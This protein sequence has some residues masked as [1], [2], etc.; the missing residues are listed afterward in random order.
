ME[1][2]STLVS[3]ILK[4]VLPRF[5]RYLGKLS[6]GEKQI[7]PNI[8]A[9]ISFVS[10]WCKSIQFYGMAQYKDTERDTIDLKID[11]LPRKFR[12]PKKASPR[13]GEADLLTDN[14]NYI[15]L[16]DPGSGK[17]T[18]LKRLAVRMLFE[19]PLKGDVWQFPIVIRIKDLENEISFIEYLAN[20]LGIPFRHKVETV[21][22][23]IPWIEKK[24][25]KSFALERNQ[26]MEKDAEGR[27]KCIVETVAK[28]YV[29]D[30]YLIN[31]LGEILSESRALLLL[32]GLDEVSEKRKA[33]L[34]K[35][36]KSLSD[37]AN[38]SKIIVSCRSGDYNRQIEGFNV[39]EIFPLDRS[40][41]YDIAKKWLKDPKEFLQ[42][43]ESCPYSDLSDRPLFLTQL[44]VIYD[45]QGYLPDQP[46]AV[47]RKMV[48]LMLE[49]WDLQ[50]GIKRRSAYSS[51]TPERKLEF[52]AA[53]SY[54]LTYKSRLKV[55]RE[56]DLVR[57]YDEICNSFRLPQDEAIYVAQEI[58]THTGLMVQSGG[59]NFEF[60]H[61]SLQEYLCAYY[62]VR[63]SFSSHIEEYLREYPAPVAIA[64]AISSD[65]SSW[66]AKLILDKQHFPYF[67]PESVVSFLSR[68]IQEKPFFTYSIALG[69]ALLNICFEFPEKTQEPIMLLLQDPYVE[70]SFKEALG[71]YAPLKSRSEKNRIYLGQTFDLKRLGFG[72]PA[73]SGYLAKGIVKKYMNLS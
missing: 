6:V 50:R 5:M 59:E 34:I 9:H 44:I 30:H 56:I 54:Q 8:E 35:E 20:T 33:D 13:I 60:S 3:E 10:N 4:F 65:P 1:L 41:K 37:Y 72:Y 55:F 70:K 32:D 16:G 17:T 69:L 2:Q 14:H 51:F 12:G 53:M 26:E 62:L 58:E 22:H 24:L 64:V 39:V 46:S 38:Y 57:V 27:P 43:I 7:E 36:I 19:E 18:T 68:L 61:L 52:L 21:R 47:Y 49:F 67:T 31:V 23:K 71:Y 15:L 66:L 40:Q 48:N 45:N 11:T 28:S 63:A 29:G 73:E 25:R 42:N